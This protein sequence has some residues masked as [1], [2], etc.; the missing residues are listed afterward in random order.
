MPDIGK[1]NP[2]SLLLLLITLLILVNACRLNKPK[3]F[4]KLS[5]AKTGISFN[6][7]IT[8]SDSVNPI[9]LEFLYNGGGVAVGDFDN[10][11]L[12][13][14]YFTASISPN[15]MYLNKGGLSFDDITETAGVKG[16]GRWA[17]AASVVDIN[18]DGWKDIYV[19]TTIKKN[20]AE[21][22]NLLYV[23][24]GL[25][26]NKVPVFHEMAAEYNLA[27][28]SHSVHAA[29]FDY[30]NDGDL[31]MYL[32]TTKMAGRTA[33]DFSNNGTSESNIDVDKLF[34]NDF[35]TR[36]NHPVYTDVSQ[37]AHIVEGGYGLGISITDIN[38]DGYKDIYVTNDFF[39]NDLLYINNKDGTFTNKA[40]TYFR[41]S[42]RNAMGND[43]AD[44]NSDGLADILTA[45]MNPEDNFRKKKNLGSN[46]YYIYQGMIYGGYN[47][48]YVRN[49]LQLNQGPS[50]T[51]QGSLADPVFSEVGFM[52]G[53]AQTDWSWNV[54]LADFDNN[55][56]RDIIITNGYPRDVTDHDFA[57]YR[58]KAGTLVSRQDLIAAIP[59]IRIPN[60]A[61][62]NIGNTQFKNVTADWG[63]DQPSFSN[64]A[65]Y[66]DLDADG[67]LDYVINNINEKAFV[68][69][70]T[71]NDKKHI[72]AN[73]LEIK[74]EGQESNRNGLGAMA[75]IYT[76][77][78]HQLYENSPYRG[79]I[80]T[81]AAVAHFGLDTITRIDSI[82]ISWQTGYKQVLRNCA[83]NQFMT[84]FVKDATIP[85][86]KTNPGGLPG[87]F[88]DATSSVGI[89]YQH[90]EYDVI[91]FDTERLLPH[92]LSQYGPGIAAGDIN[93]DG[94]DDLVMGGNNTLQPALL[95][96]DKDGRF[97]EHSLPRLQGTDVRNPENMGMLLIDADNDG[98]QDLFL[99]GGSN[100]YPA[101][102][103]NYQDRLFINDGKGKFTFD[104]TA[105]PENFTSKSC[106][107]AADFDNDGDLDLFLGGRV[108]PGS[109]PLPVN[110][111]IYRNDSKDKQ[112]KFTDITSN[113]AP[114][115]KNIGLVCD[116][117]F[118]D[119][120]NDGWT[121][122]IVTGEWMATTFFKNNKG[123]FDDITEN[124]GLKGQTGWWN[125]IAGGDFD[126]DGD[127]DYIVTNLGENSFYKATPTYPVN[128]Y[129]KDFDGNGSIDAITTTY[130]KDQRGQLKEYTAHNKDDI[131]AQLP[132]LKKKF[133]TYKSFAVATF[134]DLFPDTEKKGMIH[135]A[136]INFKSGFIRNLGQG[137][138]E[139]HSLPPEAQTAPV[140][141]MVT[142]DFNKDGNLD[143]GLV[144]NDYGT[145]V[146]NGRY[147]AFNGLVLL[148]DGSG[149]FQPQTILQSGVF[150]PG[151]AK[152][153]VKLA[154]ANGQYLLAASQN[155]GP[156][157]VFQLKQKSSLIAVK[158]S[159]RYAIVYLQNGKKRKEEFYFGN[160][161]L[162]QS[163][164]FI[165]VNEA[166]AR[167][168]ITDDKGSRTIDV[169][170]GRTAMK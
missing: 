15:A 92:K 102:T 133:L 103:R 147:D 1:G 149:G 64:G 96:Q 76:G 80:S 67:D 79:Y 55:G 29:F 50:V 4:R 86:D 90:Q 98:D 159:D 108:L 5:P 162:S 20:P 31:D 95:M 51:D 116:A 32:V 73:F 44:I 66:A 78:R 158:Q 155:R 28:T 2:A 53:V 36:L 104:Q 150:V 87:F 118:S 109:Y 157:K 37:Q 49:T 123:R 114:A 164:R 100:E 111:F 156:L 140:Y 121:D 170:K 106:A 135:L 38:R 60:Y 128:I 84:V 58:Q 132:G 120:D 59:Q 57:A 136:A 42:S 21:R 30:D 56:L 154:G 23:N 130:L 6:N 40:K 52:A 139:M 34:R 142:D 41:H 43:I 167:I 72:R 124:T 81:G 134:G 93:G 74:F 9:D 22:Q 112:I 152:A 129:A 148:G 105:L 165:L 113:M 117:I 17:N 168:V 122:L 71:T 101:N 163:S 82:I 94:L 25:N 61:F 16:E 33:V 125:S 18:N 46:N 153:L 11:G 145:E 161:F 166:V 127:I 54:S 26:Q 160:S 48:Q 151:D 89:R 39:S 7:E 115:L 14:L 3:L 35:D 146:T 137:K 8:E 75:E 169:S 131:N 47:L 77:T 91:D 10:N 27:D 63:M 126:N 68:Y 69:E 85:I 143:V 144:G 99:S 119:F 83:V 65:V 88:S 24:Q 107:K 12:P 13:D 138:F 70:N 62:Q 141:G 19:C 45:D 110:S 97:S